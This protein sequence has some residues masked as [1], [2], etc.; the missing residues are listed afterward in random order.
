MSVVESET[1]ATANDDGGRAMTALEVIAEKIA[2]LAPDEF[3]HVLE[4]VS[5]VRGTSRPHSNART[6]KLPAPLTVTSSR[7]SIACYRSVGDP[8][9]RAN[10]GRLGA[11]VF[12]LARF[13]DDDRQVAEMALAEAERLDI[14]ESTAIPAVGVALRENRSRNRA[15]GRDR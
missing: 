6:P 9:L 12:E 13:T 4:L 8:W 2:E 3:P 5:A 15:P 7:P 10:P 11:L 14:P 1:C